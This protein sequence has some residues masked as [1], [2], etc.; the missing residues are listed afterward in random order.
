[1]M[2][3]MKLELLRWI[4][5]PV[6]LVALVDLLVRGPAPGSAALFLVSGL[7]WFAMS[8]WKVHSLDRGPGNRR[9]SDAYWKK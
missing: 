8:R 2:A 1:M 3:G 6:A 9:G 7:G 4:L 5:L